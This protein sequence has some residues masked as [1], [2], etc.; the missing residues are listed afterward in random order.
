MT[1]MFHNLPGNQDTQLSRM[2]Q[3]I[4]ALYGHFVTRIVK[5]PRCLTHQDRL[6]LLLVSPDLPVFKRQKDHLSDITVND[7]LHLHGIAALSPL[8]KWAYDFHLLMAENDGRFRAGTA[9]RRIVVQ[10]ITKTPLKVTSY[11]LKAVGKRFLA[12]RILLLPKHL[13]ELPERP[14]LDDYRGAK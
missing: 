2:H 6:P 10:P 8:G 12:D 13:S 9:L 5:D 11:A 4:E 7:G 1:F 3:D 14:F